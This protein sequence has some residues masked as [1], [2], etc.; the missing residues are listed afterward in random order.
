MVTDDW[1]DVVPI[2]DAEV[3][4]IESHFAE[5]LDDLL[6]RSHEERGIEQT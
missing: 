1:P 3:R 4:V 5:E 2:S 6:G